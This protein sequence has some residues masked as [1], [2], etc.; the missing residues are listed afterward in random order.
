MVRSDL[1]GHYEAALGEV[2]GAWSESAGGE[3]LL[4]KVLRFIDAPMPGVVTFATLGLS[5]I[6][7][8]LPDGR[9]VR[10][11]LIFSCYDRFAVSSVP[12]L[13]HAVGSELLREGRALSRGEVLG[14]AGPL[15]PGTSLT[16]LYV[17]IPVVFPDGLRTWSGSDPATVIAWM[18]PIS[19]G[20]AGLIRHSG[21]SGFE[22]VLVDQDPDLFDLTRRGV[23]D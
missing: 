11:E 23:A 20:E 9:D 1:V 18:V 10:Q 8:T 2:D 16:A 6:R 13:L 19:T 5:D 7:L 12:A 4:F 14:P 21:W 22:D 17:A 3:R 15:L